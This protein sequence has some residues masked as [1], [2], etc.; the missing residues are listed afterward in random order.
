MGDDWVSFW[1]FTVGTL[2][3]G[4]MFGFALALIAVDSGWLA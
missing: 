1:I 4:A 2:L 3:I